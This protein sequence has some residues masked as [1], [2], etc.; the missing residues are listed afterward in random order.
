MG[1]T[2]FTLGSHWEEFVKRE[3]ES[4]RYA[5]ASEVMRAGLRELEERQ[6]RLEALRAHLD[7]GL[8]DIERGDV[9]DDE[10]VN[11]EDLV[12]RAAERVRQKKAKRSQ[13][14]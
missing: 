9:V 12:A 13:A 11:V 14:K 8:N 7:E 4:G 3:V 6:R 1:T 10:E 5:T 2:S